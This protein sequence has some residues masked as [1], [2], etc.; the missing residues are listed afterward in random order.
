M[1]IRDSMHSS[2]DNQRKAYLEWSYFKQGRGTEGLSQ[3]PRARSSS[4]SH[5]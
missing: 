1:S 2:E 4:G 5:P 3:K